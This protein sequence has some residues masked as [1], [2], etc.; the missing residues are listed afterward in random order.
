MQG[1]ALCSCD[2]GDVLDLEFKGER[3][4]ARVTKFETY[5]SS[6]SLSGAAGSRDGELLIYVKVSN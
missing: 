4:V 2:I 3:Y 1:K 6:K 5:K